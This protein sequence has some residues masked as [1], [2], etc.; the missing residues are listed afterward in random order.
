MKEVNP[1]GISGK[2]PDHVVTGE[3]GV[4]NDQR[5]ADFLEL[6]GV[7]PVLTACIGGLAPLASWVQETSIVL[8]VSGVFPVIVDKRYLRVYE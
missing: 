3:R 4:A 2:S 7:Y 8:R 6:S 5:N 1:G